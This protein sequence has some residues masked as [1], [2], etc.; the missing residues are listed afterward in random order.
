MIDFILFT[1]PK[2][3]FLRVPL[4]TEAGLETEGT[5]KLAQGIKSFPSLKTVVWNPRTPIKD[6]QVWW[7]FCNYSIQEAGKGEPWH[8]IASL[9]TC[10][11]QGFYS[12]RHHDQEASWG[13]LFSLYFYI[14][15]HH[16]RK[17]VLELKQVRKVEADAEAMEGC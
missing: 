3:P 5:G 12:C 1:S 11:S 2:H 7:F 9:T 17:S 14:A 8:M 4:Q 16:Q 6:R 10:L 15:V 13:G